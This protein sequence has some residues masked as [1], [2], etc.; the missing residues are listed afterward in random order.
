MKSMKKSVPQKI[1]ST[2]AVFQGL[3]DDLMQFGFKKLKQ[4][5]KKKPGPKKDVKTVIG[6]SKKYARLSAGFLGEIGDSFYKTYE[7]IK[8]RKKQERK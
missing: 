2:L 3:C 5:G 6:K 4:A 1:G 8:A 7:E